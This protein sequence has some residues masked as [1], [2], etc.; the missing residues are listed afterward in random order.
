MTASPAE[1]AAAVALAAHHNAHSSTNQL[2]A[3]AFSAE[4][5][6]VVAVLRPILA[7]EGRNTAADLLA[8]LAPHQAT[9]DAR[10]AFWRASVI[11]RPTTSKESR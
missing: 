2:G 4:A 8:G 6:A 5:R 1:Q 11:A 9:P 7:A 10:D 3:G